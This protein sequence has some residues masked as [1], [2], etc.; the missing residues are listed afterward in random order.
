MNVEGSKISDRYI[1]I[2][3]TV[4]GCVWPSGHALSISVRISK[5]VPGL[6]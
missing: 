2:L 6:N 4:A 3:N 5:V 1:N